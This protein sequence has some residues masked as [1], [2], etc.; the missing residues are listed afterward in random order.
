MSVTNID[1][2]DSTELDW[3]NDEEDVCVD[4]MVNL[5]EKKYP[6]SSPCFG[7]GVTKAGLIRLQEEAKAEIGNRK[8]SKTKA[9]TPTVVQELFD[10][11][12]VAAAVKE[13]VREYFSKLGNQISMNQETFSSFRTLVL[14]NIK[15]LFD[16]VDDIGGRLQ[17]SPTL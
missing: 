8:S 4:N 16:K 14:S 3:T 12:G 11:K 6:F 2:E 9:S 5:I 13:R 10:V 7:G 1:I 17:F 15:D